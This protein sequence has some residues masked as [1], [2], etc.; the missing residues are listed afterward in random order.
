MQQNQFKFLAISFFIIIVWLLCGFLGS[1]KAEEDL[2]S[3]FYLYCYFFCSMLLALAL[4]FIAIILRLIF[5]KKNR[6]KYN[7]FYLFSGVWN[8]IMC[9]IWIASIIIKL[10]DTGYPMTEYILINF[11]IAGIILIDFYFIRQLQRQLFN[12]SNR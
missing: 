8:L 2:F 4:G 5:F 9:V 1:Y 11:L 12:N 7:F 10:L 6:F 3:A